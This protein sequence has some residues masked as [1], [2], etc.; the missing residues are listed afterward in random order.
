MKFRF[1]GDPSD[2][3]SGPDVLSAFGHDF[4]KG[5]GVIVSEE[6]AERLRGHSHFEEV[7]PGRKPKVKD[8]QDQHR[9]LPSGA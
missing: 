9:D 5:E 8:D 3:G 7:K 1:T 2:G 6:L 4:P